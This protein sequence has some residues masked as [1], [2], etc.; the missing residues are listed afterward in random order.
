MQGE[1]RSMKKEDLDL[2]DQLNCCQRE[3]LVNYTQ[4]PGTGQED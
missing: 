1:E 4:I 3:A 2:G